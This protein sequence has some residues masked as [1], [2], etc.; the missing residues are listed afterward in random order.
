[1]PKQARTEDWTQKK[2]EEA[3]FKT[4]QKGSQILSRLQQ[5]WKPLPCCILLGLGCV[6]EGEVT[7]SFQFRIII[8]S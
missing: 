7:L 6:Q 5:F 2:M 8:E 4:E 3:G 1:M